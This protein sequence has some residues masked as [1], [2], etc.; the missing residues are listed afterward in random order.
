MMKETSGG[1]GVGV[2]LGVAEGTPS[3]VSMEAMLTP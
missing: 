2:G 1:G 3:T